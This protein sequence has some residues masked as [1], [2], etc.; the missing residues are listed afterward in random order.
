MTGPQFG[1]LEDDAQLLSVERSPEIDGVEALPAGSGSLLSLVRK[2][3]ALTPRG[4]YGAVFSQVSVDCRC[5]A[6]HPRISKGRPDDNLSAAQRIVL[7]KSCFR[8]PRNWRM[9]CVFCVLFRWRCCLLLKRKGFPSECG[10][11]PR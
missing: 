3:V 9:G 1:A 11:G 4:V 6:T 5:P 2:I 7:R 10:L 8:Y